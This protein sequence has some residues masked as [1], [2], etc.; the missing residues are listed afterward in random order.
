MTEVEKPSPGRFCPFA[1]GSFIWS[2]DHRERPVYT[3]D[4]GLNT[5]LGLEGEIEAQTDE[6]LGL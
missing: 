1:Q 3:P 6:G 5:L 4:T 2:D